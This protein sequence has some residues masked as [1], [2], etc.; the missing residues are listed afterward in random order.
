[1]LRWLLASLHLLAFGVG[2]GSIWVRATSLRGAPGPESVR[3]ALRADNW[4]GIA[5]LLWLGTGLPRLLAGTEKPTAYYLSNHLFWTK[6][7]LFALVVSLEIAPATDLI[8][9]RRALGRGQS[10]D[11]SHAGRW[12]LVSRVEGLLVLVLLFVA[13]AMARGYGAR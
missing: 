3:R 11:T 10:P 1:M 4:W 13:T 6:M 7:G 9:W 2:L 5:A 8:R 12:A